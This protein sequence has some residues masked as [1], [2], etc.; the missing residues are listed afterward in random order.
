[1]NIVDFDTAPRFE[2]PLGLSA[3][4]AV[5][6]EDVQIVQFTLKPEEV[7]PPHALPMRVFFIVLE[8]SGEVTVSNEKKVVSENTLIECPPGVER[9]WKAVGKGILRVVAIK[10]M[11]TIS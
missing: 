8:G 4:L 11:K 6:T 1:M 5:D 10:S 7:I 3:C 9:G 2:N